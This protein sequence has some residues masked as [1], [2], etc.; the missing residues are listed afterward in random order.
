MNNIKQ[1]GVVV[2]CA[3]SSNI[4]DEYFRQGRQVGRL[5]AK[6]GV[7][8]ISGGGSAGLM[9]A[10]IEGAAEAGGETIGILPQFMI[11]KGWDHPMLSRRIV[12]E[13]M[14][15]RKLMMAE[16]SRSAIALPGGVGTLDELFEIITWRQLHIFTGNVVIYNVNGFYNLLFDHLRYTAESGFMRREAPD[17]LW[18]VA[19][20]ATEAVDMALA[21]ATD[22]GVQY[23]MP[24]RK[25]ND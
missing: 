22:P 24:D 9:A 12:T 25:K 23:Q 3:S 5:L 8:I 11:D 6:A 1:K 19:N 14:H 15:Q 20:N 2:Y 13:T 17:K 21:P 10:V 18:L 4:A 7:P 16:M